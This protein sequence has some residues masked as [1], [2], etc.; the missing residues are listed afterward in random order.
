M[1]FRAYVIGNNDKDYITFTTTV[2]LI[3][4]TAYLQNTCES[5]RL[6]I[7]SATVAQT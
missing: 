4:R 1:H 6:T 5:G 7:L 3:A 2:I